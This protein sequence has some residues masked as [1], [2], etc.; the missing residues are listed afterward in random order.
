M[1]HRAATT[2]HLVVMDGLLLTIALD[3]TGI[4]LLMGYTALVLLK[5]L[6][7]MNVYVLLS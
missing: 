6:L 2:C 5:E 7:L 3:W 4:P 1:R